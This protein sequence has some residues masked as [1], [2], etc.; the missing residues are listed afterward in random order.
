MMGNGSR[1]KK[2]FKLSHEGKKWVILLVSAAVLA[3]ITVVISAM[4]ESPVA[5][6]YPHDD[7]RSTTVEADE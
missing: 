1:K 6:Y 2:P 7:E 3:I 4:L 5:S